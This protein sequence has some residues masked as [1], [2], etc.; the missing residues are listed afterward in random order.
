MS[1]TPR[2]K[3]NYRD[4]NLHISLSD[5]VIISTVYRCVEASGSVGYIVSAWRLLVSVIITFILAHVPVAHLYIGM[6]SGLSLSKLCLYLNLSLTRLAFKVPGR[7]YICIAYFVTL[8]K[9]NF[10]LSV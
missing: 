10:A 4:R 2:N 9:L 1:E 5:T 6:Y 3:P 8:S 7:L